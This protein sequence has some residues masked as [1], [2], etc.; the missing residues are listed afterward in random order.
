MEALVALLV[1][2]LAAGV[3]LA[4]YGAYERAPEINAG[5]SLATLAAAVWLTVEIISAGP[6]VVFYDQFFVD[7]LNVFLIALTALVGFS[8][9]LFSR[10][11]MRIERDHGRMTPGRLR[12]YHSMYQVF[13]FTMLTA[14]TTNNMVPT[15]RSDMAPTMVSERLPVWVSSRL[16]VSVSLWL[17]RRFFP[18]ASTEVVPPPSATREVHP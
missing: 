4:L 1:C 8:T 5:F 6:I 16:P 13:M 10:P 7:P 3:V 2:P 18:A 14:L 12:L 17:Q 9:S 11:Y 15:W